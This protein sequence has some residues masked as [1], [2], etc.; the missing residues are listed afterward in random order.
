MKTKQVCDWSHS[1]KQNLTG[2]L[3]PE[4]SSLLLAVLILVDSSAYFCCTIR[5]ELA[6]C[7]LWLYLHYTTLLHLTFFF[8]SY[9]FLI[10][11][12]NQH[13]ILTL[14]CELL[15]VPT[16]TFLGTVEE[17]K[18]MGNKKVKTEHFSVKEK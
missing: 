13:N 14:E 9:N 3:K 12:Q 15:T 18:I 7:H 11:T 1:F 2:F 8:M 17:Y 5:L 4:N 16:G 6:N 10:I